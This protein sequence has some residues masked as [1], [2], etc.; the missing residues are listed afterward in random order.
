MAPFHDPVFLEFLDCYLSGLSFPTGRMDGD[1]ISQPPLG[2]KTAYREWDRRI[3]L[4]KE[5]VLFHP[6]FQEKTLSSF[7][8]GGK[9][10]SEKENSE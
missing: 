10:L 6:Q 5:V 1:A 7:T 9:G 4:G 3:L 8:K 2:A